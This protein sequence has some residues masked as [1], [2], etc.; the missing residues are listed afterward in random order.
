MEVQQKEPISIRLMRD[1]TILKR[2]IFN[3]ERGDYT[4]YNVLYKGDI[5]FAK[6]LDGK[7][8]EAV[9]LSKLSK[10]EK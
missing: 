5:F 2:N 8:V 3:T 6:V 9:N 4:I 7:M 1:G 10:K